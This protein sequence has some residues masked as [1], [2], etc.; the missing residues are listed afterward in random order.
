MACDE[1]I[2]IVWPHPN[3]RVPFNFEPEQHPFKVKSSATIGDLM[4]MCE[5]EF[6]VASTAAGVG[7]DLQIE[8]LW[9]V[10]DHSKAL[11]VNDQVGQHFVRGDTFGIYGDM[12]ESSPALPFDMRQMD[13]MW[14]M[15]QQQPP[16]PERAQM[17]EKYLQMQHQIYEQY[18]QLLRSGALA[19]VPLR[20]EQ[21]LRFDLNDRVVC[22]LGPRWVGGHVVGTDADN[23]QD[24]DYLVKVDRHPGLLEGSLTVP[25]DSDRIC[26]QE[27][28]FGVENMEQIKGAAPE[29]PLDNSKQKLRFKAGDRVACRIRNGD[30]GLEVWCLGAVAVVNAPLPGP[31]DWGGD[32]LSGM[33]PSTVAYQ[34]NLDNGTVV[35]CHA[36]NYTL[37]RREGLEPQNRVKG[38]SKRMEDRQCLDGSR[39]RVDH[40]SERQRPIIESSSSDSGSDVDT[41]CGLTDAQKKVLFID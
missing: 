35:F 4:D 30:D 7:M 1:L 25:E 12:Q 38:V 9:N 19:K 21:P 24:W 14:A 26:I 20:R 31:L 29:V 18:Q 22:N 3:M 5:R 23:E 17:F 41:T 16:G 8:V 6:E 34:V 40:L 13:E 39:I 36:D 37:I 33:Y 15:L 11:E 27:V 32:G 10:K 28:C 2:L